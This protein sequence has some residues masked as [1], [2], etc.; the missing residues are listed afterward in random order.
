[1]FT[2]E[3]KAIIEAPLE[4]SIVISPP[5]AGKTSIISNRIGN[6]INDIKIEPENILI[7]SYTKAATTDLTD[8]IF[9]YLN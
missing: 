3:Q 9:I 7:I 1:M 6:I 8:T 4:L 5:G 2:I